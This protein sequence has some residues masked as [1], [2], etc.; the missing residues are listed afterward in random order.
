MFKT[1]IDDIEEIDETEADLE[2][3]D[4]EQWTDMEALPRLMTDLIVGST[5]E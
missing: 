1:I 5:I 2:A 4:E 3:V